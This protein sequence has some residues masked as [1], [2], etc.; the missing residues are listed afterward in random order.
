MKFSNHLEYLYTAKYHNSVVKR[1]LE[2]YENFPDKRMIIGVINESARVVSNLIMAY[3]S[4]EKSLSKDF[5]LNISTFRKIS[6]KYFDDETCLSLLKIVEIQKDSKASP[7]EFKKGEK[8]IFLID[9]KY[10]ILTI[11]KLKVLTKAINTAIFALP[12]ERQL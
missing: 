11:D 1:M 8:I 12:I 3:L 9:G 5:L 10:K 2:N 4:L 7:V 6:K